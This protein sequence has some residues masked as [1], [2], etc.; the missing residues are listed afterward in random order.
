NRYNKMIAL[1]LFDR[2]SAPLSPGM[3]PKKKWDANPD[4]AFD[5]RAMAVHAA[6]VDRL[7]QTIGKLVEKLKEVGEWDNTIIMFL[8]DNG[9]SSE[10]PSKYGP[11]FDRAG[12]LRTGEQVA[13]PVNK[14]AMP[15]PQ[16]VHAGI[17]P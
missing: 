10:R 4:T 1:G 11:G 16:T 6:M 8:S 7:D 5:A 2:Q 17:G 15:G 13:F 3:F 9:A 14:D 12:S